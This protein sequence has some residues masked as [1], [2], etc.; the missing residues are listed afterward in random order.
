MLAPFLKSL[1][2]DTPLSVHGWGPN[3]LYAALAA[4][5]AQ[6]PFYQ[7]DPK[8]PFGWI[9]PLRVSLGQEQS[10]PITLEKQVLPDTSILSLTFPL[11]RLEYIQPDPLLFPPV[12]IEKGLI[13]DGPLPYWLL[14]A[15]V[16]L[17]VHCGVAWIGIHHA[18]QDNHKTAIVVYS[19]VQT[20]AIGDLV[21]ISV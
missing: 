8:L 10:S 16:R 4:H 3:W 21:P 5:A 14:T 20:H 11:G 17:Y 2:V 15:L 1:P 9:Q 7:F 6:Q 19:R 18:Q 13:L 12:A